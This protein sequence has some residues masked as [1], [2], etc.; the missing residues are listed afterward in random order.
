[1]VSLLVFSSVM[2]LIQVKYQCDTGRKRFSQQCVFRLD[3]KNLPC[4]G[5]HVCIT[6]WRSQPVVDWSASKNSLAA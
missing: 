6:R 4:P 3:G 5:E 1:M 2:R